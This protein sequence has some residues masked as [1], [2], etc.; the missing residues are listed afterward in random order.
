M[1]PTLLP[2]AGLAAVCWGSRKDVWSLV[3]MRPGARSF[4]IEL[5]I[6]TFSALATPWKDMPRAAE[7]DIIRT[8]GLHFTAFT[9]RRHH[10]WRLPRHQQHSSIC[11]S[12]QT[13]KEYRWS[14]C[15]YCGL[16]PVGAVGVVF[17]GDRKQ[18]AGSG[19]SRAVPAPCPGA[20][21]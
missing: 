13:R 19:P 14:V 12:G 20:C 18:L 1:L 5:T 9:L 7:P 10:R 4:S 16:S 8:H 3:C 21:P 15:D 2:S 11:L 6:G 17:V